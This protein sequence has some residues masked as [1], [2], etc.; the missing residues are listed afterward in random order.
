M[1]DLTKILHDKYGNHVFPITHERNVRD[2]DGVRLDV[3]LSALASKTAQIAWD[4]TSAPV[5]ANIPAG[6]VVT[7]D[8]TDY[9]GTLAPSSATDGRTFLVKDGQSYDMYMSALDTGSNHVWVPLG[10]S[11][12]TLEIVDNLEDGGRDKALS[13]EQGKVLSEKIDGK[14]VFLTEEEFEA[15]SVIE[16]DKLYCTYEDEEEL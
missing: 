6:V 7:Y 8:G 3:K 15:L 9:T 14:F 2:S 4:G 5:V 16:P 12:V 1:A 13:A 11:A 10:S